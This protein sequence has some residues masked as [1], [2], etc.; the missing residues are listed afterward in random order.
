MTKRS[1]EAEYDASVGAAAKM[2]IRY[3]KFAG[4]QPPKDAQI[5]ALAEDITREVLAAQRENAN[6]A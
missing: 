4:V 5:W 3:F 2:L 6:A 1:D